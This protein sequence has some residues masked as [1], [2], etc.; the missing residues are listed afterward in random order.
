MRPWSAAISQRRT[1]SQFD[2]DVAFPQVS[3]FRVRVPVSSRGF[4]GS[5]SPYR[6]SPQDRMTQSEKSTI[7][8]PTDRHSAR[9]FRRRHAPCR[10]VSVGAS[11]RSRI[12][13]APAAFGLV[14]LG[15]TIGHVA[16]NEVEDL[17][18]RESAGVQG[19]RSCET[20][21]RVQICPIVFPARPIHYLHV[22]E[23][24]S[25]GDP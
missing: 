1:R 13:P 25:V 6:G 16:M 5:G 18:K 19:P 17:G 22:P 21:R 3:N 24:S 14:T 20:P 15:E 4:G 2:L 8:Q 9:R 12:S 10:S 23:P 11:P 7:N